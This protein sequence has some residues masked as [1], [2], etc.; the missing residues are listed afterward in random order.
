MV[1]Y[2]INNRQY[3][4]AGFNRITPFLK[5]RHLVRCLQKAQMLQ[6]HAKIA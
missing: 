5:K 6:P 3:M 2:A 1:N 4:L